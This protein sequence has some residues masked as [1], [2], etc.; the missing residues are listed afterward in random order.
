MPLSIGRR[1]PGVCISLL[2]RAARANR[3]RRPVFGG[4]ADVAEAAAEGGVALAV[5]L[6]RHI[7]PAAV[8]HLSRMRH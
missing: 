7:G 5:N 6:P 2:R 4:C 1:H 3:H 8:S